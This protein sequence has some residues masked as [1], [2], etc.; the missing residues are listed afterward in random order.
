MQPPDAWGIIARDLW[1][2][3]ES[4]SKVFWLALEHAHRSR[5]VAMRQRFA[6]AGYTHISNRFWQNFCTPPVVMAVLEE[7]C[8]EGRLSRQRATKIEEV[9]LRHVDNG[10][11][12]GDPP[13]AERLN[14]HAPDIVTFAETGNV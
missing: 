14:V 3:P 5:P 12:R 9:L 13:G 10:S 6:L 7:L 11:W 2:L 8:R 1:C 4:E